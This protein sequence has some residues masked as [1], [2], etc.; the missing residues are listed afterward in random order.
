[1]EPMGQIQQVAPNQGCRQLGKFFRFPSNSTATW[2]VAQMPNA[3][4][5]HSSGVVEVVVQFDAAAS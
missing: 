2:R 1:M 5:G 4:I 3:N